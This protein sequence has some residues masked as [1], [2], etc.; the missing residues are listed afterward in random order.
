MTLPPDLKP[1]PFCGGPV[2]LEEANPSRDGLYGERR[3]WGVTCRNTI[4]LGGSCCMDQVPSA[5][6]EA[7]IGRWNMRNGN[8]AAIA[9]HVPEAGCG[10]IAVPAQPVSLDQI[11]AGLVKAFGEPFARDD[12]LLRRIAKG[13]LA[14]APQ[15]VPVPA[16]WSVTY[17]GKRASYIY[18]D[19]ETAEFEA[20][21][22]GGTAR[23]VAVYL[24][25]APKEQPHE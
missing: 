22:V 24:A 6:K 2:Q 17:D 9:A 3:W 20:Q 19:Q 15:A 7:A 18:A 21:Q 14:A 12:I 25:A 5:S 8:R 13:I 23:A 4:N 10:N 16:G 1:C 11:Q